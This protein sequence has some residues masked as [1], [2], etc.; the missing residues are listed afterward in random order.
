MSRKSSFTLLISGLLLTLGSATL[1]TAQFADT[2]KTEVRVQLDSIVAQASRE[3]GHELRSTHEIYYV[4]LA[5]DTY[6]D[7]AYTLDTGSTYAF[8]GACDNDCVGLQLKLYDGHWNLVQSDVRS[9]LPIVSMTV[10]RGGTAYL[11]VTMRDCRVGYCW[12]G[13]GV[14]SPE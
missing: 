3:L 2:Y 10:A 14:Y 8:V 4:N 7:I 9:D 11:R 1:A 13:V 12:A 6:K 5:N